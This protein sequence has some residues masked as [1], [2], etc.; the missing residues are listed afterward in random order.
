[1]ALRPAAVPSPRR[2]AWRPRRATRSRSTA[3]TPRRT[4]RSTTPSRPVATASRRRRRRARS[5]PNPAVPTGTP[6]KFAA[7][8]LE[9]E[10]P[11]REDARLHETEPQVFLI[12]RPAL[13]LDGMRSY[14]ESVGGESWLDRRLE[15]GAPN[16]GELLVEFGG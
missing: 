5:A 2:S 3:S 4:P 16:D 9:V 13:D 7:V 8:M 6:R 1:P 14:L 11:S 15:N 12:A 10:R